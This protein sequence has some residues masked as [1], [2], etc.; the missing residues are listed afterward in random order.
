MPKNNSKPTVMHTTSELNKGFRNRQ[1]EALERSSNL[2]TDMPLRSRKDLAFAGVNQFAN[3]LLAWLELP[4][5]SLPIIWLIYD[6]VDAPVK[7][8]SPN[9]APYIDPLIEQTNEDLGVINHG[10]SPLPGPY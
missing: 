6:S 4:S 8:F 3:D 10:R 7:T 9:R 2:P 5:L 1:L